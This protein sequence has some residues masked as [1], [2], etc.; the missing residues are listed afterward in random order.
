[1]VI[2]DRAI[3]VISV[4]KFEPDVYN[5]ELAQL[6]TAFAAQA[7]MAIENAR[8]LATERAA[9]EQAETLRAAAESLGST[10]GVPEVFDVILAEL[11]KVVP[12][13]GA[14]V[15]Q[16]DGN[17]LVIVGGHGY[18]NVDELLGVRYRV[19][20][21]RGSCPRDGRA[22]RAD[23]RRGRRRALRALRGSLRPGKHQESG[24]PSRCSSAIA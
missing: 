11:R 18:P 3:G 10:L 20:G 23:H 1:M 4:D 7:A 2:G 6:A 19:T 5:E 16:F 12:Y 13:T 15:Q 24:W 17:E 22:A 21:A 14:S 8:L 9:R